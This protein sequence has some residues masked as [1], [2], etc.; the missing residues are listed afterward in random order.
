[1]SK[2]IVKGW[3]AV[4]DL[5]VELA[6]NQTPDPSNSIDE[7][8]RDMSAKTAAGETL[9]ARMA[10]RFGLS[11]RD[12]PAFWCLVAHQIDSRIGGRLEALGGGEVNLAAVALTAYGRID[13]CRARQHRGP[14]PRALREIGYIDFDLLA[15]RYAMSGGYIRNA[16]LR[17]AFLAS[18]GETQ[19][20]TP[21]LDRAASL[22]YVALGKLG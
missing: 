11:P 20:T 12:E 22:E 13:R 10:E 21:L 4:I 8:A 5:A 1:M 3:L 15:K 9:L 16:A 14:Q 19:I 2:P 6:V 17:A 7:C 18:D